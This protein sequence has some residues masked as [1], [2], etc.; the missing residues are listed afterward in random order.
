MDGGTISGAAVSSVFTAT[1]RISQIAYEL[2]AVGEQTRDLLD[3]TNHIQITMQT[4]RTLR[5]QKS[6]H[7]EKTE[8]DWIDNVLI[9]TEKTLSNVA[10]LIEPARVDMQTKFGSVGLL[11]RGMFVFRDSPK[12]A[13]NLSRLGLASQSLNTVMNILCSR[14]GSV[15]VK[16]VEKSPTSAIESPTNAWNETVKQPPTYDE[17]EFLNRRRSHFKKA[18]IMA[19]SP[20]LRMEV[21]EERPYQTS[22]PIFDDGLIPV[23]PAVNITEVMPTPDEPGRP[24]PFEGSDGLQ[25][26]G[27]PFGQ[28]DRAQVPNDYSFARPALMNARLSQDRPQIPDWQRQ[29]QLTSQQQAQYQCWHGEA[30]SRQSCASSQSFDS[31]LTGLS[32]DS[33]ARFSS[34]SL[35]DEARGTPARLSHSSS[36]CDLRTTPNAGAGLDAQAS[37]RPVGRS[38][39]R[40][41]LEFQS[42][43]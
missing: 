24:N 21:V 32:H 38:Q 23:I 41:W 17:S 31:Q 29:Q 7:L 15:P 40:A 28:P 25:V 1:L 30:A 36:V 43:R 12:V 37:S 20:V 26:C 9:N 42:E 6:M 10:M 35:G 2:K 4:V 16:P 5:R 8:K 33:G 19:Q 18:P 3:S 39:R 34:M 13:T 27:G 11:R 14:D 22:A